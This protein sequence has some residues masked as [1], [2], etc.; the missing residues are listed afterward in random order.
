VT[1]ILENLDTLIAIAGGVVLLARLIV[2]LTPTPRDDAWLAGVLDVLKHV[3][4]HIADKNGGPPR[5][6]LLALAALL[7]LPGCVASATV[8]E[9]QAWEEAAWRNYM[10]NVQRIQDLALSMYQ[11]ERTAALARATDEAIALVKA[12]AVDGQLPVGEFTGALQAICAN[13]EKVRAQTQTLIAK[14]K[15]LADANATEAAKAL[16]LHA[17]MTEWLEAGI[18]ESALPGLVA[19]AAGLVESYRKPAATGPPAATLAP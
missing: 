18:D 2:K 19:E 10:R 17:K 8:R 14:V 12:A 9:N 11:I 4:L 16:R 15:S 13:R 7:L 3:G 1:W 5:L 6:P